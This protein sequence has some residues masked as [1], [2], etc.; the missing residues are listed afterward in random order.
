[1]NKKLKVVFVNFPTI[2]LDNVEK[3][4]EIAPSP[5]W[6]K[7]PLGIAHLASVIE[8]QEFVENIEC[9]D[10][11][12][13]LEDGPVYGTC[14]NFIDALASRITYT[15]DVLAY[16]INF[17]TQHDFF[18][19]CDKQLREMWPHSIALAGGAHATNIAR[20][21]FQ[22]SSID[23]LVRGEA[24][25]S[26]VQLLKL[27]S[28]GELNKA[29]SIQGVYFRDSISNE[30]TL[31]ISEYP[32][33]NKLPTPCWHI[34][35]MSRYT[36][37]ENRSE[38]FVE[39]GMRKSCSIMTSR[40]CPYH[41]TF[42]SSFS[43]H[44]RK[45]RY[46]GVDWT[47]KATT[48]LYEKY[49]VTEFI[50]QDDL[51]TVH[52]ERT[53]EM[54]T[55]L[56]KLPI[57]DMRLSVKNAL[58]INTLDEEVVEALAATGLET[59]YLA[60]ESGSDYVNR[61]IMKKRVKLDRVPGIIEMFR[62]RGISTVCFFILGFP[63]ETKE[64]MEEGIRYAA[65]INS[66]WCTFNAVKPLVGTPL[67]DEMLA[68]GYIDHTAEFWSQTAY[69]LRNFDTKEID[70]DEL[71]DLLYDA[72]IS[73]NF[74][75]NFNVRT[76][77]YGVAVNMFRNIVDDYPYHIIGWYMLHVCSK[78]IGDEEKSRECLK[79]IEILLKTDKRAASMFRK[80]EKSLPD[81]DSRN[82]E[83]IETDE[84][85]TSF[86]D[87]L[88]TTTTQELSADDEYVIEIDTGLGFKE[89]SSDTS[90]V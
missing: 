40:G 8:I 13:E 79:T 43:L 86:R 4:F 49:G 66:D 27:I 52:K 39:R 15:P 53:I 30:E 12:A 46:F 26:M 45:M 5:Y 90:K 23:Y 25:N 20:E 32:D 59:A 73:V 44:G 6:I 88:S 3:C 72:N 2:T 18:V 58:S 74:L 47:K 34:F 9:I 84:A 77:N 67:Y 48:Q 61:D 11:C 50:I 1:M 83:L 16:S 65:S 54:L 63:G 62:E 85:D 76:G 28:D 51:F 57:P 19:R 78:K 35:D 81:L 80:Y 42:C 17:S 55:E 60:V 89:E 36:R 24:E 7:V 21:I 71:N 82:I 68:E 38:T 31:K 69:G 56:Q 29:S 75:N 41:C 70:K 10:Y 22:E 64:M 37:T 87:N 33:L 14:E